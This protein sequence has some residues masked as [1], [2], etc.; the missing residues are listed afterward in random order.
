MTMWNEMAEYYEKHRP[1]LPDDVTDYLVKSF[2]FGN[3]R[4]V[5][6][7]LGCGTGQVAKSL[8]D[9][10]SHLYCIDSSEEMIKIARYTNKSSPDKVEFKCLKAEDFL[11]PKKS[12]D[13]ITISRAFHWMDQDIV[14]ENCKSMLNPGGCIAI[15]DET[16][17]WR[18]KAEWQ[19]NT[20]KVIQSFLGDRRRAGD[21]L[22]SISSEPY[23][24][25]LEKHGYGDTSTRTFKV[26]RNWGFESILGYLY[27]TSFASPNLFGEKLMD[28]E[29]KLRQELGEPDVDRIFKEDSEIT[30]TTGVRT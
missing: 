3:G 6:L 17:L 22:F 18:G 19:K 27:S 12:V 10:V 5:A 26:A 14:L 4:G 9:H 25:M 23:K 2:T 1:G 15:I 16:S 29:I 24:E 20:K 11:L 21:G 13:L 30:I 28:F 8:Y 7:D